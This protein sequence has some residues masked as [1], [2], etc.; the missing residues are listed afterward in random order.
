V[1]L[2][3][4]EAGAWDYVAA[5]AAGIDERTFREW[6][7]RG[8]GRH[9]TRPCTPQLATFAKEVRQARANA[10][11]AREIKVADDAPKF[12]LAH[13]ARSRPH[14][15]GWSDPVPPG[16][17]GGPSGP[18]PY[19]PT[20]QEAAETLRVLAEAG[21]IDLPA[22]PDPACACTFHGGEPMKEDDHD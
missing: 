13:A 10:R 17:E 19:V 12:W 2:R 9:P 20:M 4:I 1:I 6:I 16:P 7:E 22:C 15:E 11:A 3:Y 8:E 5:E 14:R 21:V 18:E